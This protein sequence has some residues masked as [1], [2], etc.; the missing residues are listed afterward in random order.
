MAVW[1]RTSA[2]LLSA[3]L[4]AIGVGVPA[5]HA[6]NWGTVEGT[7]VDDASA[8]P[9][10][11]VTVLVDGTNFGTATEEDGTYQMRLPT[12]TYALRFSAVGYEAR[13]DSVTVE[14]DAASRV[15]VALAID[16]VEMDQ[17]LVEE[18]TFAPDA[19]VHRLDPETVQ[20][21]PTPFKDG[22]R[23][24]KVMPGVATNTELSQQYSVR[25]GGYNENLIFL[26]G[27]EVFMPF[28]P[29]QGEQEGLGLLNPAM[30]ERMTFYTGGFPVRYGGKL[31]S[32]LD[33]QYHETQGERIR[34]SADLSLLDASVH[35][36]GAALDD[37]LSWNVG[38]RHAQPGRFFG[39]QDLK[40]DYDPVFTD[41]QGTF[42]YRIADGHEFDAL[43]IYADH[44]F[45][46]DPTNQR[47]YFGILSLDPDVPSNLQA[48]WVDFDGTR[49]DGYTTEFLGTR[50]SNRLSNRLRMS[51][52][53]AYFGTRES[54]FFSITGDSE[55]FRVDPAG[56][57]NSGAGHFGIGTST[58]T[59]FADNS[60]SVETLSG[61]G[62]YNLTLNRNAMEAGWD[63]R[64]LRFTD[65]IDE[66]AVI[67]TRVQRGSGEREDLRIVAD[68]LF[69][70]AQFSEM[71][72]GVYAENAI[73]VLPTRGRLS[74][75]GG[76]RADYYSFNEEWTFSPRLSATFQASENLS[77][78][79]S[80]GLYHQAPTYR[81]LRGNPDFAEGI[82]DALNRD[83]QS[84]RSMQ[85]V[86]GGEYF[87]PGRRLYLRAEGYYKHLDNVI[88]YTIED[89]RVQYSGENDATG[90]V[91]GADLQLRGELI[92]GLESWFNYSY[93]V[94]RER[95]QPEFQNAFNQ[96]LVPRPSDQRH[97]FSAFLQ[98]T[99]PGDDSWKAHL[100]LLFGSGLP[101]T[102]PVP[103]PRDEAT[104]RVLQ[105]PGPRMSGR[106]TAYRR[107][108]LGATKRVTLFETG[109]RAP[110][111]LDLTMELLNV[112]DM[113]NTVSFNWIPNADNEWTRVP[114]R[115]TPR[116]INARARIS[117]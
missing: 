104:G 15:D 49:Q 16:V 116:T 29:R 50:L 45:E 26:N 77:L 108:D 51:H 84:Q 21:M 47:T 117:F 34:G 99:I 41:L 30:A 96:G 67:D 6:Q 111:H 42:T 11:G 87:L 93:M 58:Q 62:R 40:G 44:Q 19:G 23:A 86:L 8:T 38:V 73:D 110:V 22:F 107:V 59:D 63:L 52:Q 33:V 20:S 90:F 46:L 115:L 113:T 71:Q 18:G 60:V 3:L 94:A 66:R 95:I 57:P 64:G 103:G 4:V 32:A 70:A 1:I 17:V 35:A 101:Y 39:T 10:P 24:L 36:R 75:T 61:G 43:G 74:V 9:L 54:E 81:E 25:G 82:R 85:V 79:G 5:V 68:S 48:L 69:D 80:W 31:S 89:I 106:I 72:A 109:Q 92:P 100:R 12:G 91:Y 97:T 76:L 14:R 7:V 88:S 105:I 114:N 98:D 27:F 102:P 53:L 13:V 37:R 2:C 112:F 65:T 28:R 83:I 78:S 56:D 55:L